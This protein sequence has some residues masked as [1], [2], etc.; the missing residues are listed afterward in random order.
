VSIWSIVLAAGSGRRYDDARLKQYEPLG[1]GRVLD[2]SLA[3]ARSTADGVVLVVSRPFVTD[4][5]PLADVVV[6]G[7]E[8]R[9]DS[10]R[11]GLAAVPDDCDIVVVHDAARPLA[12]PAL[13]D[14]VVEAVLAGADAAIPGVDVADTIKRVDD[15]QV[16]A[17]LDR[18]E[19]V[20]VQTPQAFRA[21]VLRRAH[22]GGPDATDDAALV[23]ALGGL[24]IVVP[25]DPGNVKITTTA[26]LVMA[27]LRL[28]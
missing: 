15:G 9:S 12:E 8:R 18:D 1:S 2:L 24:V 5:E 10:V 20:A 17:T 28:A 14:A 21:D 11:C 13:F 19:L 7:G 6:E 26:D 25:G 27:R 4:P 22:E 16:T 23:E 3:H